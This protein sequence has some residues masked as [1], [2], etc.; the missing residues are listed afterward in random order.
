MAAV[1]LGDIEPAL[2]RE[3][4]FQRRY[5]QTTGAHTRYRRKKKYP[6][7]SNGRL[8]SLGP[9]N[10][11]ATTATSIQS[12]NP[13]AWHAK[14]NLTYHHKVLRRSDVI[15]IASPSSFSAVLHAALGNVRFGSKADR[16][17]M[18][19]RYTGLDWGGARG[20]FPQHLEPPPRS[21]DQSS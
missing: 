19:A 9:T 21:P 1:L 7:P 5:F 6:C 11:I 8:K 20:W 17:A 12:A 18:S 3:R 15:S 13:A 14:T 2:G 4:T 16:K 10:G